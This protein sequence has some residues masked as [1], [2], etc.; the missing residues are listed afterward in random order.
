MKG[1]IPGYYRWLITP[2]TFTEKLSD[3]RCQI[4]EKEKKKD[5]ACVIAP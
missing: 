2:K 1:N 3:L 5:S 4:N